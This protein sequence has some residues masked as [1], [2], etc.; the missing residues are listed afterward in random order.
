LPDAPAGAP[1]RSDFTG[2][3]ADYVDAVWRHYTAHDLTIDLSPSFAPVT[4]RV[5]QASMN[6]FATQALVFAGLNDNGVPF[7][8]PNHRDIF[9]CASGPLYNS[10]PD[11]RGA[12]AARL[13]AA[14]NRSTL[15]LPGGTKQPSADVHAG[16]YYRPDAPNSAAYRGSTTN[17]FARL[18]HEHAKIGYAFPYDDVAPNGVAAVD[19]HIQE[20]EPAVMKVTVGDGRAA[21]PVE[22]TKPS[23]SCR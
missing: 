16:Q 23:D 9:G 4:G 2:Y 22:S 18:V 5:R 13:G 14:L 8:K 3:W 6:G 15:L 11:A 12:V 17:H 10:G 21:R 1:P 19:G 7:T 20:R